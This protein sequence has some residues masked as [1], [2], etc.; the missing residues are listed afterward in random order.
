ME[1]EELQ[2]EI[3]KL[4]ARVNQIENM[5]CAGCGGKIV[6]PDNC[7]FCKSQDED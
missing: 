6:H 4:K 7:A 1:M 3:E 5:K 2:T